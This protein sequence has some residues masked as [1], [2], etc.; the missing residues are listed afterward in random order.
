[1]LN[2]NSGLLPRF[3]AN[4]KRQV[5]VPQA[6]E[7]D[8]ALATQL[9][10][11]YFKA[12]HG[13]YVRPLNIV[14]CSSN[15]RAAKAVAEKIT[16]GQ[17]SVFRGDE[18][19]TGDSLG[20]L[21]EQYRIIVLDLL[22]ESFGVECPY[23]L[24]KCGV[25]IW[26]IC[27]GEEADKLDADCRIDVQEMSLSEKRWKLKKST[28]LPFCVVDALLNG[29]KDVWQI[30][31]MLQLVLTKPY[32]PKDLSFIGELFEVELTER[33]W[34]ETAEDGQVEKEPSFLNEGAK[35]I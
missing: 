33:D 32:Q 24:G 14:I 31:E 17:E 9:I 1:M 25:L 27:P 22:N 30:E 28:G 18:S 26:M 34:V 4:D 6:N 15:T 13:N 20:N 16:A 19:D 5:C 21:V 2:R 35:T 23:M 7:K 29:K 10:D 11:K 3:V 12:D 8:V